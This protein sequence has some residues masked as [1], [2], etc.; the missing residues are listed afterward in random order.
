MLPRY[1]IVYE[2]LLGYKKSKDLFLFSFIPTP[3]SRALCTAGGRGE[4]PLNPLRDTLLVLD[5]DQD[6]PYPAF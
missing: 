5:K 2:T 4:N 6:A 1:T 3:M